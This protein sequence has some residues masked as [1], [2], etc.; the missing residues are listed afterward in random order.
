MAKSEQY[1]NEL[2]DLTIEEFYTF[3]ISIGIQKPTSLQRKS[4]LI[5][6]IVSKQSGF[7]DNT[8]KKFYF[9]KDEKT[10]KY[11]SDPQNKSNFTK[12]S[13]LLAS[14]INIQGLKDE[15][16]LEN[17]KA[18]EAETS[19]LF[20]DINFQDGEL[21]VSKIEPKPEIQETVNE[22][23]EEL[24][25][26]LSTRTI[27][28]KEKSFA[29][30]QK[31]KYEPSHGIEAFIRSVEAFAAANEVTDKTKW[32]A[33]AK[34]ALNQS[35]D[36]LLIQDSLLPAEE[37]EWDLFKNKL[38]SILGRAPDYYRDFYRG[39]RRGTQKC[40]LAMSRLTQAYKRVYLAGGKLSSYDQCHI[41]LQFVESLD[42]PLRGLVKAEESKLTF[43]NIAERASELERCFGRSFQSD[44]AAAMMFPEGRVMMANATSSQ[45][46]TVQLRLVELLNTLTQQSKAQHTEMLKMIN[47]GPST[48]PM[49]T[50]RAQRINFR[51]L[52][53]ILNGHC[54][55][56]IKNNSCRNGSQCTFKHPNP[57][58]EEMKR[59]VNK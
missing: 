21:I 46:N 38:L 30:R 39:F 33:I 4:D 14:K 2:T 58:P 6:K 36:G 32:V 22:N 41:K 29:F 27:P 19:I 40:G 51:A 25:R 34:S 10:I 8:E 28:P 17:E 24:L 57:I 5:R 9:T 37:A 12:K 52:A 42:N 53:P 26:A 15:I 16:K 45:E 23:V 43:S 44:S 47:C 48:R 11:H 7:L 59:A 1:F 35:E 20:D 18:P 31:I 50:P 13:L 56:F 49:S 3:A 55:Y 54:Y